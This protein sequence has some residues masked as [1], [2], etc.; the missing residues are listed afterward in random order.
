MAKKSVSEAPKVIKPDVSAVGENPIEFHVEDLGGIHSADVRLFVGVNDLRGRNGSGKTSTIN[1]ISAACGAK[2]PL[3]VRDGADVGRVTGNG[4]TMTIRKVAAT[5]G[6]AEVELA[7]G[8]DLAELIDGGGYADPKARSKA[9]VRALLRIERLPVTEETIAALCNEDEEVAAVTLRECE[10]NLTDD[11]LEAAERARRV[12]HKLAGSAEQDQAGALAAA[13]VHEAQ[14]IAAIEEIGGEKWA[15]DV[16]AVDAAANAQALRDRLA[17]AKS[18]RERRQALEAQQ[19][20]ISATL[21]DRPDAEAMV[22]KLKDARERIEALE[23]HLGDLQGEEQEL[24]DKL[25]DLRVTIAEQKSAIVEAKQFRDRVESKVHETR[26]AAQDWDRRSGLLGRTIEG[27]TEAEVDKLTTATSR[28]EMT[29]RQAAASETFRTNRHAAAEAR[30][31]A[32]DHATRAEYLRTIA[33]TVQDRLGRLLNGTD[34]DGLTVGA[35]GRVC[36][37]EGG[38]IHDFETRRSE[39]QQIAAALRFMARKNP[40]RVIPLSGRFWNALDPNARQTFA[41]LSAEL[42]L[43]VVTESPDQGDLRVEHSVGAPAEVGS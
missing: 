33:T 17:V 4:V 27:P 15:V 42:G 43:Y 23:F 31:K 25:A 12:A 6:K 2:L 41:Q 37:V 8:D 11:L 39:G 20:E 5:T 10:D 28:A 21:G 29:A 30:Q 19:A 35:D 7:G 34:A 36:V 13:D 32:A 1:A 16:P 40:N 24:S 22:P 38:A 9:R 3:E 18:D 14:A 26:I